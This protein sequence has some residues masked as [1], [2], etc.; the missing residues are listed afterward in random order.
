[1]LFYLAKAKKKRQ[2]HLKLLFKYSICLICSYSIGQKS[3]KDLPNI[4]GAGKYTLP[5]TGE[6]NK[7][8][9]II[10]QPITD[11]LLW[12]FTCHLFSLRITHPWPGNI[13]RESH[14]WCSVPGAQ[15]KVLQQFLNQAKWPRHPHVKRAN[16]DRTTTV[17]APIHKEGGWQAPSNHWYTAVL[18]SA[19][20]TL[21]GLLCWGE[22]VPWLA[23]VLLAAGSS[24][25]VLYG[26]WLH[27]LG[28][29]FFIILVGCIWGRHQRSCQPR[30]ISSF[31]SLLLAQIV[32]KS[33]N[34][35]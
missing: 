10:I 31:L 24:S 25:V 11:R 35:F 8:L 6:R 9:K 33:H 32:S 30:G 19:W 26:S 20:Q 23:H 34:L 27:P 3:Y 29:L 17:N 12:I 28:H 18:K 15:L 22:N 21:W 1:M 2:W 14:P 13:L 5:L 16:E 7:Y 4:S